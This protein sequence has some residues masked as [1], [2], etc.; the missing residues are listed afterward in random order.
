MG[1]AGLESKSHIYVLSVMRRSR[2]LVL[3]QL[4]VGGLHARTPSG[5]VVLA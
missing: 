5:G 4:S 2:Y 3:Y 1:S